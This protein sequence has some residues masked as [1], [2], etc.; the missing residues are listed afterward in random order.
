MIS[1]KADLIFL[2]PFVLTADLENEGQSSD[3]TLRYQYLNHCHRTFIK[4]EPRV[5]KAS[6][7]FKKSKFDGIVRQ[8]KWPFSSSETKEL[9]VELS[10]HKEIIS[11]ALLADT[12]RKVQ[13]SLSNSD[14]I[15]KKIMA[16]G[17][18]ARRIEINTTIVVNKRKR[19]I[20]NHFM[21]AN[22]Q[23]ALQTSIKLRH[24]MTGLW[25][26]ESP[27]FICW[28]E[29]PGSKLWL[30]GIPGAGKAICSWPVWI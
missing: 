24:S 7:C 15:D 13:L 27:T 22:P 11:V 30:T 21:K 14:D 16:L 8:L 28:L 18:V 4:I 1:L 17:E 12:M 19:R 25:L 9:L 20:L 6:E 2:F 23:P 3:P 29:T 5:K 10:R 26:T